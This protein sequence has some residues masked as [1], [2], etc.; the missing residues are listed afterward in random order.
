MTGEINP[1]ETTKETMKE[2]AME[3]E[4][5]SPDMS[6]PRKEK[7]SEEIESL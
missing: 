2:T 4:A 1:K 5:T 7:N 3:I 6:I